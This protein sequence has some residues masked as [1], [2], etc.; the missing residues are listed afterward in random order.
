MNINNVK[1]LL[2]VKEKRNY[3]DT[4]FR[5]TCTAGFYQHQL[6]A[7]E[8]DGELEATQEFEDFH[9]HS[10]I[11]LLVNVIQIVEVIVLV[12]VSTSN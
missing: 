8:L 3:P 9:N 11:Q 10:M 5:N 2:K 6:I 12:S 1:L 7:N 4:E